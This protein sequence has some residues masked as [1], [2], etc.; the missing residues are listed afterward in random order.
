M[1]Y[2]QFWQMSVAHQWNNF[3]SAPIEACGDRAVIIL[4]G[5]NSMATHREIAKVECTKRGYIGYTLHKGES[6]TRSKPITEF[7]KV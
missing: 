1:I 7:E 3:T 2:A 5:R 6:F 4:D